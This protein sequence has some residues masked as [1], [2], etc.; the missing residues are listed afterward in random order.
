[1]AKTGKRPKPRPRAW[2]EPLVRGDMMQNR[3]MDV[4]IAAYFYGMTDPRHTHNGQW[5]VS[6]PGFGEPK[7][8][9]N[10]RDFQTAWELVSHRI[11]PISQ[12][13][14]LSYRP[15]AGEW[16]FS[17]LRLDGGYFIAAA[18]T[19]ALAIVKCAMAI[20]ANK[21]ISV[22]ADTKTEKKDGNTSNSE[23]GTGPGKDLHSDHAASL[24][25]IVDIR[26]PWS[27]ED[28]AGCDGQ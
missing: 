1:M 15:L 28:N 17:V 6:R 18:P 8:L 14:S 22:E 19:A 24:P 16:Q 11:T 12:Q 9:P 27:G 26:G 10:F 3:D 20:I 4:A 13:I 2:L 7:T 21:G 23:V 5:Y 25:E